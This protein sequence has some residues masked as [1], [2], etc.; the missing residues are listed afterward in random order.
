MSQVP[1]LKL[2][3]GKLM[4]QLGFGLWQVPDNEA[5]AALQEAFAAG[6]RSVDGAKI[7]ENE[8][9]LGRAIKRSGLRRSE[10]FITTKLWNEDQGRDRAKS[11]FQESLRRLALAYVD[12][13]LIHWPSPSRDL[14]V[15]SWQTLIELREQGLARSIGVS[16]FTI[17]NLKR[18]KKETGVTPSVNQIELHPAFQQRELR[19]YHQDHGI[20]TESWSP[21]GQG[22]LLKD[23]VLTKIGAKYKKSA[24]QVI[25][26][27]H[28]DQGLVVIPKSVTPARIR[29]NFQVLDF[30]LDDSDLSAIAGLDRP[31]GRIGPDSH[32]ATF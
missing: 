31:N 22:S 8:E 18:L 1:T 21:L 20:V 32:T 7:Y 3:D 11:A 30:K 13:Y 29:E 9:G 10:L 19:A 2:N 25:I 5:E 24:A 12:L 4:P 17:E 28:L 14:Y 6:Y 27:W 15:D 23:P 26:R 16:N